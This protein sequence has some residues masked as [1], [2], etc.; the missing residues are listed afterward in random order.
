MN[1]YIKHTTL[2]SFCSLALHKSTCKDATN[3]DHAEKCSC[4]CRSR[5]TTNPGRILNTLLILFIINPCR[6]Q[7][8]FE[9]ATTAKTMFG[10][11]PFLRGYTKQCIQE[12]ENSA[13]VL[14]ENSDMTQNINN[15]R[16][17]YFI[18]LIFKLHCVMNIQ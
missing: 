12:T 8:C 13:Q 3:S 5:T 15:I 2:A 4:I 6:G 7:T 9:L 11:Y 10:F 1:E 16:K 18:R 17:F 14:G